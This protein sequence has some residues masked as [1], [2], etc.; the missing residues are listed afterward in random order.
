MVGGSVY[1]S[2]SVL[3][4]DSGNQHVSATFWLI[5]DRP[6]SPLSRS[7]LLCKTGPQCVPCL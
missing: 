5:L 6:W 3:H 7:C 2:G 1:S 4:G